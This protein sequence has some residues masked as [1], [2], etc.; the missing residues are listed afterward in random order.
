MQ[1]S[2]AQQHDSLGQRTLWLTLTALLVLVAGMRWMYAPPAPLPANAPATQF[3]A[4]RAAGALTELIGADV[5]HPL[6]S[7]A[8]ARIR[9]QL[10]ARLRALGIPAE[11]Q[12]GWSCDTSFACGW[13]VNVIV[14]DCVQSLYR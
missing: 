11:L 12:S 4:Q 2:D 9:E 7:P 6:A 14:F 13:V 3:S 1:G 8:D 5:P 10:L